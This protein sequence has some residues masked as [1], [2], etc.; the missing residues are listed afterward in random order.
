MRSITAEVS[1]SA[2][3]QLVNV[4][5]FH[6]KFYVE[7][8]TVII[9]ILVPSSLYQRLLKM[10][11]FFTDEDLVL[12]FQLILLPIHFPVRDSH[13]FLA[14]C[15]LLDACL[16]FGRRTRNTCLWHELLYLL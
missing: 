3:L 16:E 1:I 14:R 8:G 15:G 11:V 9:G 4:S 2:P 5:C 7:Y 10:V 12:L 13:V 6:R